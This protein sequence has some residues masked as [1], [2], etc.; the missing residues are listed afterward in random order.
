MHSVKILLLLI[1]YP[2]WLKPNQYPLNKVKL[3]DYQ[4]IQNTIPHH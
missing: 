1:S 4:N 3:N 2:L